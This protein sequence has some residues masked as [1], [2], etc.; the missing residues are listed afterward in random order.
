[1]E[2]PPFQATEQVQ[3]PTNLGVLGCKVRD[4]SDCL[5]GHGFDELGI[6]VHAASGVA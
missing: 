5:I 1:M 3:T 2:G 4:L 6:V